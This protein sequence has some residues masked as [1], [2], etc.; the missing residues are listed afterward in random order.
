MIKQCAKERKRKQEDLID[1]GPAPEAWKKDVDLLVKEKTEM[2]DFYK[3]KIKRLE[4][5]GG[6]SS[7][8]GTP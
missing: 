3:E 2:E 1:V 4:L 6:F 8:D 5:R 7:S